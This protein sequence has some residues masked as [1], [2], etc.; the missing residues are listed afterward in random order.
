MLYNHVYMYNVTIMHGNHAGAGHGPTLYL[1]AD[2]LRLL[3]CSTYIYEGLR[4]KV[5]Y[6]RIGRF[7]H[8]YSSCEGLSHS[9]CP[10][11]LDINCM[12]HV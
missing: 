9:N 3:Y 8:M 1:L 6:P 11:L 5:V 12:S 2:L 4:A 10:I 7:E